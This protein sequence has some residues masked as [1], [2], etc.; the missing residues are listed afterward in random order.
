MTMWD[1]KKLRRDVMRGEYKLL[2]YRCGVK[3]LIYHVWVESE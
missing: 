1:I 2:M 3:A